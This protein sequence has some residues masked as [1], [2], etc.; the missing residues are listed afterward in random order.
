MPAGED[1]YFRDGEIAPVY[2]LVNWQWGEGGTLKY[3]TVGRL[4]GA[5]LIINESA[6][7]WPG[8][9]DR[10]NVRGVALDHE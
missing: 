6:I 2:D 3:V 5:E 1:F 9:S 8:N 10:V 4:E 7:S